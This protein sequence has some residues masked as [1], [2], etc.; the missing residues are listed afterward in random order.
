M[1]LSNLQKMPL[2]LHIEPA[3]LH[4]PAHER[5]VLDLL[6][7]YSRDIMGN[8]AALPDT[9]RDALIEGL[10]R[11]PTSLVLLAS[12]D[13]IYAGVCVCFEVF[14][15][16]QAKPIL[17][18]HDLT[19]HPQYRNAGIG[20]ALLEHVESQALERGCCKI[21][22]EVR[23]DNAAAK[24]LYHSAGFHDS[25]PVMHFWHKSVVLLRDDK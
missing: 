21:T 15:T 1:C 24:H 6:D 25:R 18:V 8:S 16:F 17:N 13:S 3:D 9:T 5:A 2:A 14:S 22:L 12:V 7:M 19:V 20:R 4:N 11:H 23:E 10:R